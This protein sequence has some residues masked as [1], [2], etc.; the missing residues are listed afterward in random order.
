[1]YLVSPSHSRRVII[2]E[3]YTLIPW[4]FEHMR[5]LIGHLILYMCMIIELLLTDLFYTNRNVMNYAI[6]ETKN[7]ER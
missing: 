6:E 7:V 2:P 1:M 5:H 4:I 3:V